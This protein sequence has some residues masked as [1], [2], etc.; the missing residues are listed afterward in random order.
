MRRRSAIL[1]GL[2]AGGMALGGWTAPIS[3]AAAQTPGQP[4][5][6]ELF[7]SQGCS[8]CPPADALL[9]ELA[10]RPDIIALAWHV[11]YWSHLGWRDPFSRREWSDRQR[12]YA[13]RLNDDVYTPALIV[14]GAV[15][16]VGS[17][18]RAVNEAM[19]ATKPLPLSPSLRR[20]GELLVIQ[21]GVIPASATATL[22]TYD[23]EQVTAV[24]A[25]EN[26]GRRL[27]EFQVVR[28][29]RAIDP[30]LPRTLL[31]GIGTKEGIALLVQDD[32][33][34]VIGAAQL[35]PGRS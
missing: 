14:N 11:D 33:L 15:M 26:G 13:N 18:R 17:N 6:L 9:G 35:R 22:V 30:S 29:A 28:T 31:D 3:V 21:P 24:R 4:V 23:P 25:G 20:D 27:R 32:T 2:S 7:T 16:V 8:S 1:G 5:V 10:Q 19:Q 12:R 34:R